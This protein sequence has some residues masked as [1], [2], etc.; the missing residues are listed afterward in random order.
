MGQ[1]PPSD[2]TK[3]APCVLWTH[4]G[5]L[6]L[7][8]RVDTSEEQHSMSKAISTP[9][10]SCV[11]SQEQSLEN[12]HSAKQHLTSIAY[13]EKKLKQNEHAKLLQTQLLV[14]L[15]RCFELSQEKGASIWLTAVP[16]KNHGFTLHKSAF[17]DAISLWCNWPC[18]TILLWP[19]IQ[20]Y[21]CC[22][23]QQ[24]G[25]LQLG[26]RTSQLLCFQKSFM[27]SVGGLE[28]RFLF[29]QSHR[30]NTRT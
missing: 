1:S 12:C 17:R 19:H 10:V 5:W 14:D 27:A 22:H 8:D 24:E 9:L 21:S 6:S 7:I 28:G 23:V 26:W 29:S 16:I 13:S 2:L 20:H 18:I 25:F 11:I 15:Q 3:Y 30:L 4:L